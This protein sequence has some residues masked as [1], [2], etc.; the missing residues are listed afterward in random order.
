MLG[1]LHSPAPTA[2]S[3]LVHYAENTYL[4]LFPLLQAYVSLGHSLLFGN[5]EK[6]AFVP[7]LLTSTY[8]A[9]GITWSWLRL[10]TL[11]MLE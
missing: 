1:I 3:L 10:G 9:V 8:C 4:A 6:V 5:A 11:Y 2:L 7:L